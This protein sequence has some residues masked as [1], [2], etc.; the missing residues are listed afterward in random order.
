MIRLKN[1]ERKEIGKKKA[2][3]PQKGWEAFCDL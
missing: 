3:C 1:Q 2:S